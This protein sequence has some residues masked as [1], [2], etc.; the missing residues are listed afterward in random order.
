VKHT[1]NIWEHWTKCKKPT[2][3]CKI[4]IVYLNKKKEKY[5]NVIE[6]SICVWCVFRCFVSSYQ[7]FQTF[8]AGCTTTITNK[9]VCN[10][11]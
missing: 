2:K 10:M 9:K 5:F 7:S 11:V 3:N 4:A 8:S 6:R 1:W